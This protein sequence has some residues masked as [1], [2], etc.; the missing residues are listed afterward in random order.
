MALLCLCWHSCEALD[1]GGTGIKGPNRALLCSAIGGL[2]LLY[3]V[4]DVS[5]AVYFCVCNESYY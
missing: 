1:E 3:L 5:R 2:V 4:D